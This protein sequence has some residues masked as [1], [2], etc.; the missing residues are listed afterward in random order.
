MKKHIRIN[1]PDWGASELANAA[2]ALVGRSYT[3]ALAGE[4]QAFALSGWQPYLLASA[5]Y[6]LALAVKALGVR[7]VAV[8]GYI[9]PAALTGLRAGGAEIVAVDCASSSLLFDAQK[10]TETVLAGRVDAILAA[11]T[12]GIDQDYALLT[13]LGLPVIEDAAYQA[14]YNTCG[15]RGAAGVWSFNFKALTAVG[16]GVLWLKSGTVTPNLPDQRLTAKEQLPLF[17]N[18]ALRAIVREY[19]PKKL[20]GAAPPSLEKETG[21]RAVLQ[22]M[23]AASMSELQAAIAVTQWRRRTKLAVRQQENTRILLDKV[24]ASCQTFK[25]LADTEGQTKIHL[26]PLLVN[27]TPEQAQES[28]YRVRCS[29]YDRGIQTETPYP[30]LLGG[31]DELPNAHALAARLLLV[32]CNTSL[33]ETSIKYIATVLGSITI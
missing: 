2:L 4:L 17:A 21:V 3:E 28:V 27:A 6:G 25:R 19:L 13:N 14:G 26:F 32:P 22:E 12:Y 1:I 31:P 30:L 18:Y 10:L 15:V 29:L 11:N 24:L 33:D 23:R 9:C 8:P 7:R 20:G 16:G 5:R